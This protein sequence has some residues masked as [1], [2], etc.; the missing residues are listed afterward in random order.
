VTVNIPVFW[1]LTPYG[2][3]INT[4]VSEESHASILR[5]KGGGDYSTLKMKKVGELQLLIPINKIIR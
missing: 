5:V 1:D 3:L 4:Y 2:W